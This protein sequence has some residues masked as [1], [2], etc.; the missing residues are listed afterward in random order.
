MEVVD[1]TNMLITG[2]LRG[3]L[4][5]LMAVGLSLVFGVM[6]IPNFAH[7]EFYMLGAYFA[8]FAHVGLGLNPIFSFVTAAVGTF[9]V[10]IVVERV[11]FFNL[12]KRSKKMWVMNTFLVTLGISI[13]MQSGAKMLWGNSYRG[14]TQYWPGSLSLG[15]GLSVSYDRLVGFGI[16]MMTILLF[17]FFL[18]KTQ[19]GRA[20]RAVS[21]DESGASLVGINLNTIHT[22]TFGLSCLLA[23]AAGAILLSI[24]PAYPTMG[25]QPLYKSWFVLIL[26]GMGNVGAS[27]WGGFIVGMLETISYIK[28]GAGWQDVVSLVI[29]ILILI[30]MP[31]GLFAKKGVKSVSE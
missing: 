1:F 12:R 30:F 16:A 24:I 9:I 28:F 21:Q 18:N 5:A 10:G 15:S 17:W 22:L 11:L 20:I 14:V 26:V 13:I 23:G 7:G 3:G 2:I 29:I 6:N 4:Y 8:Y 31:R 19:S 25:V 27:I